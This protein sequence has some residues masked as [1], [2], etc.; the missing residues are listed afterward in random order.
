LDV[1]VEDS[2]AVVRD[3]SCEEVGAWVVTGTEI[4]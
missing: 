2:R 4:S 3:A 1:E